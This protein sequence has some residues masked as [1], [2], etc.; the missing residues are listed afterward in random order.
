MRVGMWPGLI[1]SMIYNLHR[2]QN[3]IKF[4]ETGVVFDVHQQKLSE[5]PCIA[6][7]LMGEQGGMNWSEVT[8]HFDFFDLKGDLQSLFS[9]LKLKNVSFMAASH[10]ALHPGQSAR[11]EIN[12]QPVGWIGVLHPRLA[13]ALEIQHDVILFELNSSALVDPISPLYKPIS[14]YP[15]IRRDLSFLV[16][17]KISAMEIETV[18]RH[19]VKE[20]WLKDFDVF[21]VYMGTG[22]P[23]G[24]KS[25]AI[26]MTLQDDTRTLID[27]EINL[28]ISAIINSLEN[29]FSI[30]LRE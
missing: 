19:T 16:D 5:R 21:D 11:I 29:E 12:N 20:N 7:L 15:Q 25:L 4:F 17:Q 2:Q 8:R 1:A 24:K 10:S 30:L 28:L 18:V 3:A 6:G 13:D 14:K 9:M 27:S 26:A 23:D 22:I